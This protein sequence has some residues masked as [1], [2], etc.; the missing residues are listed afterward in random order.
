MPR[1]GAQL[2]SFPAHIQ[3]NEAMTRILPA[4][5]LV[6][7]MLLGA[8]LIMGLTMDDVNVPPAGSLADWH[9]TRTHFLTGV[10]A[11]LFVVFV[12]SIVVTYF[13]G[14]SRWC[15]EVVETYGLDPRLVIRSNQLKRKTFPW[16]LLGM[17]AIVVVIALGGAADPASGRIGTADWARWHLVAACGGVLFIAWTYVAAWNNVLAH[18]A[19]TTEILAQVARVRRERRL[20][21]PTVAEAI[22]TPSPRA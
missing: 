17:L 13:I 21:E 7:V 9:P 10:A 14:T 20:D 11:A 4:L 6:S 19:I 16:A 18:H 5:A 3:F 12:E 2:R 22:A 8:A 1:F 15:R